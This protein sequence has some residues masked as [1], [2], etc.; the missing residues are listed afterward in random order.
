MLHVLEVSFTHDDDD[1]ELVFDG[2]GGESET[3][4]VELNGE[5][6]ELPL[7]AAVDLRNYLNLWIAAR[8]NSDWR[9]SDE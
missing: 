5:S 4:H 3:I 7:D 8:T 9:Q 6:H 2:Y 1:S